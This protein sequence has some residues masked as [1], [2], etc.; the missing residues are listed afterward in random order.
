M[1]GGLTQVGKL[2]KQSDGHMG[3]HYPNLCAFITFEILHNR[4]K[5]K[6]KPKPLK[7]TLLGGE[8]QTIPTI[9]GCSYNY[10]CI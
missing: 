2:L 8:V 1:G 6:Q 10:P 5:T 9:Y 7:L 4:K 3:I